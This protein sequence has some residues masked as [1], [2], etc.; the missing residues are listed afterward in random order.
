MDF[1]EDRRVELQDLI[2]Q[3]DPAALGGFDVESVDRLD[4]VKIFLNGGG[5]AVV[6][7]SGTEPLLRMYAE[8]SDETAVNRI[9]DD[10]GATLAV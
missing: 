1:P 10:L 5:W 7:M 8:A 2:A 6:R 9:L 3:A 4:G